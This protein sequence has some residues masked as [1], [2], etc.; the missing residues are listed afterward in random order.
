MK[1]LFCLIAIPVLVLAVV[2][3]GGDSKGGGLLSGGAA[4][5][6]QDSS[7]S[8]DATNVAAVGTSLAKAGFSTPTPQARSTPSQSPSP[9][10]TQPSSGST[11]S[12]PTSSPCGGNTTAASSVVTKFANQY[13]TTYFNVIFGFTDPQQLLNLF[14]PSCTKNVNAKDIAASL[15]LLKSMLPQV[16]KLD[17][18]DLGKLNVEKVTGGYKITPADSSKVRIKVKGQFISAND[19]FAKLGFGNETSDFTDSPLALKEAN[20]KLLVSDCSELSDL[21]SP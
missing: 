17:D 15:A 1:R 10:A 12:A 5:D 21:A 9:R 8:V 4:K 6:T 3:C 2:A 19:Y 14:D 11:G 13:V 20:G 16:D 7:P 18:V